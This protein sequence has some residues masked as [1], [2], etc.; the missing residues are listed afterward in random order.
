MN[1][2]SEAKGYK[3]C[4]PHLCNY[5]PYIDLEFRLVVKFE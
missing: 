5:D 1:V 4:S 3:Q 2:L